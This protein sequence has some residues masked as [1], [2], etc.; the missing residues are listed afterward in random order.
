MLDNKETTTYTDD[1]PKLLCE[2][3]AKWD[4]FICFKYPATCG[5]CPVGWRTR[6]N[7]NNEE[8]LNS[9]STE[10]RPDGCPLGLALVRILD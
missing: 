1:G 9:Y 6:C 3:T 4:D 7:V 2:V 8:K 5:E 10:K